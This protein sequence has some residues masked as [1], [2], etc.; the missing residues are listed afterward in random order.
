V[1]GL[2]MEHIPYK[3]LVQALQDI[4]AGRVDTMYAVIGG[5]RPLIASGQIRGI[6]VSGKTRSPIL[7]DV[8]TFAEAG[9]PD[10]DAS[11]YFGVAAPSGTPNE[12][13]Q[14]FASAASRIVNAPEFTDKYL[15]NLG[16]QPVGDTPEQFAAFLVTDRKA[17]ADKVKASGAKLD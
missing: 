2:Q 1:K 4:A 12:A 9:E 13:I 16:F 15:V 5:A 14:K 8:P 3:G 10:L 7:P 17:A 6:A 11:F